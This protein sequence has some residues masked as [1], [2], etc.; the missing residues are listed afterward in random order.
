M[1]KAVA[2]KGIEQRYL[3]LLNQRVILSVIDYGLGLTTLPQSNLLKLYRVHDEA[4]KV[5]LRTTKDTSTEAMPSLLYLPQME[6]RH[7]VE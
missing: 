4:T 1:L 2:A 3:F 5:I 6:T 7:K